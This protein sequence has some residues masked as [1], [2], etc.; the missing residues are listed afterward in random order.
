MEINEENFASWITNRFPECIVSNGQFR[1][2]SF[3]SEKPDKEKKLY[4]TPSINS[5]HCFKTD[6][7]G[8]LLKFISIVDKIS[9]AQAARL[10]NITIENQFEDCM[11]EFFQEKYSKEDPKI[12]PHSINLPPYSCL[13]S[14]LSVLSPN[15]KK[16]LDYLNNRK[17]PIDGLYFCSDGEYKNRIIIPYYGFKKEIQYWNARDIT[18][19]AYVKYKVPKKEEYKVGKEDVIYFYRK[20]K[21]KEIYITE[22][23][24]DSISL[25]LSGLDS[26][27]IGGKELFPKQLE[28]LLNYKIILAFDGD[29]PGVEALN[30]FR[31]QLTR[32][33]VDVESIVPP[34]GYKDWNELFI[35]VGP[36][37]VRTYIEKHKKPFDIWSNMLDL[38]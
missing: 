15:R 18:G 4:C 27:A 24:F 14:E 29:N 9:F 28:V 33:G 20:P 13:I 19:K 38:I 12:I 10:M 2:N 21:T 30:K 25:C 16:T 17:I 7:S 35:K 31:S 32:F 11:E 23:E 1:V 5:Y 36:E 22:G 3:F 37:K 6:E 34:N 8:N 26:A